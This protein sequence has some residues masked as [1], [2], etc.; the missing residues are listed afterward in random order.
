[1]NEDAFNMDVR[2]FLKVLGV[3]SQREI[4]TAVRAALQNGTLKPGTV[5]RPKAV[6]SIAEIGLVHEIGGEIGTA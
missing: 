4:E 2:K 3:T 6:V 5:L 1:M